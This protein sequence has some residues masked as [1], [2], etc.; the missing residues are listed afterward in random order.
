QRTAGS[1]RQ[2]LRRALVVAEVSLAVVLVIGCGLVMSS[3]VRLQRVDPG[4]KPAGLVSGHIEIVD[5]TYPQNRDRQAFW[6]HL[7]A[8]GRS[9]A[10]GRARGR[11]C[12]RGASRR[13]PRRCACS[14][15]T[16]PRSRARTR[17]RAGRSSTSTSGRR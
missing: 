4:F 13:G 11:A 2:R 6:S 7:L 12:P 16:T 5:K 14:T 8:V 10:G 17:P 15:P 9:P 3:F 1:P